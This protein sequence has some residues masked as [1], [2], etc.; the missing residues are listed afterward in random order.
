MGE[1]VTVGKITFGPGVAALNADALRELGADLSGSD[2]LRQI[3]RKACNEKG[4]GS[5]T[6]PSKRDL[7]DERELQ[8]LC[9]Q[10][11]TR[12]G[13]RRLTPDQM[14]AP[15]D[16]A[17]WFLHLRRAKGN[18]L[19]PDLCI[20]NSMCERTLLIELKVPGGRVQP[21]QRAMVDRGAWELAYTFDEFVAA[22]VRWEGRTA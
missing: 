20:W 3:D 2:K 10:H 21:H 6:E 15:G 17:G 8:R 22:L 16:P 18:A 7:R 5:V 1:P 14:E 11:L 9:E 12:H 4:G 19:L 13:Y